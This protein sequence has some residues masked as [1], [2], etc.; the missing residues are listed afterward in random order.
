MHCLFCLGLSHLF[1]WHKCSHPD[2]QCCVLDVFQV[3]LGWGCK[4]WTPL[5]PSRFSAN[6]FFPVFPTALF[7]SSAKRKWEKSVDLCDQCKLHESLYSYQTVESSKKRE[8]RWTG[9]A[10]TLCTQ[11]GFSIQFNCDDLKVFPGTVQ[12]LKKVHDYT[13]TRPNVCQ[14]LKITPF[15]LFLPRLRHYELL[16]TDV[17]ARLN[18][19]TAGCWEWIIKKN[20]LF[21]LS[22]SANKT[23][24]VPVKTSPDRMKNDNFTENLKWKI[25]KLFFRFENKSDSW[26][27]NLQIGLGGT[28]LHWLFNWK[29]VAWQ[30]LLGQK[31]TVTDRFH[32]IFNGFFIL[33][34]CI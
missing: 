2:R 17:I 26:T 14:T 27:R 19:A 7:T 15:H 34:L 16:R 10:A 30:G 18:Y 21:Q 31:D 6:A 24:I 23:D 9:Y 11:N 22:F 13:D 8:S 20:P 4:T 25:N 5:N 33:D 1:R 3:I 32:R 29:L 28:K 12:W